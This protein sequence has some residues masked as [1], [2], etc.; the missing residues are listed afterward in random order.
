LR[1]EAALARVRLYRVRP[2]KVD[3]LR[4]WTTEL[5][6][7]RHEVNIWSRSRK[8]LTEILGLV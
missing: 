8:N 4:A 5:S 7:G 6:Q 3:R 2:E 1:E